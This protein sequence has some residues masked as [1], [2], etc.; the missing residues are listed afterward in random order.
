[1]APLNAAGS[2]RRRCPRRF[3]CREVDHVFELVGIDAEL[4]DAGAL[5]D[6]DVG[7]LVEEEDVVVDGDFLGLGI[8][9]G[10]VDAGEDAETED[11]VVDVGVDLGVAAVAVAHVAEVVGA[12]PGEEDGVVR[13]F[14][15]HVAVLGAGAEDVAGDHAAGD[16]EVV[17]DGDFTL[18]EVDVDAVVAAVGEHAVLNDDVAFETALR[19]AVDGVGFRGGELVLGTLGGGSSHMPV[20]TPSGLPLVS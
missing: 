7:L 3:P 4:E 14:A 15:G 20:S 8:A 19:L 18:V 17:L 13:E 16:E 6:G 1:M 5:H 12:A 2:L 10:V 9:H 11:V